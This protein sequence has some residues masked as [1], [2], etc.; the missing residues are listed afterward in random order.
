M[1]III[2]GIGM[3]ALTVVIQTTGGI[4]VAQVYGPAIGES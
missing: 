3:M 2:V 4:P 1:L